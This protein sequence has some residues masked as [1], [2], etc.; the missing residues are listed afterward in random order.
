MSDYTEWAFD[1]ER[2]EVLKWNNLTYL[3]GHQ[4]DSFDKKTPEVPFK[5]Q[6]NDGSKCT[7]L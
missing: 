1:F 6:Q 2:N 5:Q 3:S 7:Q 4:L